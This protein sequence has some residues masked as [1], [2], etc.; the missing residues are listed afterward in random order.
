M[1]PGRRETQD[2]TAVSAN[3]LPAD[4]LGAVVLTEHELQ[5]RYAEALNAVYADAI[6]RREVQTF[7]DMLAW[8]LAVIANRNGPQAT[9]D[10]LQRFGIHLMRLAATDAAQRE[11]EQAR[12]QGRR[13][14]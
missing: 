8:E 6:E 5:Q 1:L 12:E 3:V 13:L 14:N 2:A 4:A 7:A 11:A 9:G 10:I